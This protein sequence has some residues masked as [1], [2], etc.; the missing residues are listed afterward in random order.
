MIRYQIPPEVVALI[1][2]VRREREY[3]APRL[4]LY[5]QRYHQVYVSPTTILKLFRRHGLAQLG[6]KGQRRPPKPLPVPRTPGERLQVDVKFV[7]RAISGKRR[8]YQFTAIDESTRF[9]VLRVYDHNSTRSAIAFLDEVRR[10]LPVA[11]QRVQ[12][13]H[14]SEFGWD[15]TWHLKEA[16]ITHGRI[17]RGYP[18]ANGKVERSHRTDNQ[19]FY[20]RIRSAGLRQLAC[21]LAAWEREY[22][23]GR[24][25]M[26][27]GGHTPAEQLRDSLAPPT[28]KA[29]TSVQHVS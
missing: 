10:V 1:C 7:P 27:L 6:W 14:G 18:E 9:R 16:G 29:G 5:L 4:S 8:F 22:N 20:R 15:F 28:N 26:A 2:Q 19:E 13:D 17:P 21:Q 11:I 25:H 23:F 3:G 12:T 24:P